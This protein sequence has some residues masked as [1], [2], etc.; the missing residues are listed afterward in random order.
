[1]LATAML[2]FAGRAYNIPQVMV[3]AKATLTS[4]VVSSV[5]TVAFF[6]I[7]WCF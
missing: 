7:I 6:F 1:M 3:S 4:T 2:V 5:Q